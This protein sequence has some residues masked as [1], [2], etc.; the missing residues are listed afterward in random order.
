MST[1]T[2][3]GSQEPQDSPAAIAPGPQTEQTQPM[4]KG[5]NPEEEPPETKHTSRTSGE[6]VSN[7]SNR[8]RGRQR[9]EW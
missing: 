3:D 6:G 9:P 7:S 8:R 4:P 2:N 1:T 5:D